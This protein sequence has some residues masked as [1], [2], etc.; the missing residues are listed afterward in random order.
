MVSATSCFPEKSDKGKPGEISGRKATDL[1]AD[2]PMMARLPKTFKTL[3]VMKWSLNK[4]GERLLG[5]SPFLLNGSIEPM[6]FSEEVEMY[7]IDK[8]LMKIASGRTL[9]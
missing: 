6:N 1:R 8:Y 2:V 7:A 3:V 4:K 9:R 5:R